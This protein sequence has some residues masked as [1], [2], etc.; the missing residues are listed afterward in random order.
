MSTTYAAMAVI[1]HGGPA[2]AIFVGSIFCGVIAAIVAMETK[3]K[4]VAW[5]AMS[6]VVCAVVL[7]A[8]VDVLV[9]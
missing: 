4:P 3:R 1:P 8:G 5:A 2:I 6:F 9:R 7:S